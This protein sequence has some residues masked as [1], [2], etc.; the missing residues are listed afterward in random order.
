MRVARVTQSIQSAS[1]LLSGVLSGLL[2]RLMFAFPAEHP[3]HDADS[4]PDE[5]S[6]VGEAEHG[7]GFA[8]GALRSPREESRATRTPL[9]TMISGTSAQPARLPVL[10]PSRTA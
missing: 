1:T 2:G 9:P 6:E 4:A 10:T 5:E 3:E 7:A 8:P